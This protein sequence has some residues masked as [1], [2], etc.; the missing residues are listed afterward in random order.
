M[1]PSSIIRRAGIVAGVTILASSSAAFAQTDANARP[2]PAPRAAQAGELAKLIAMIHPVGD[3]KVKGTVMFEKTAEGV[4]IT[5]KVGGLEPDSRH[6]F[7]IHEYGDLGSDDATSAGGH[8]NP[9]SHPHG[10]PDQQPRH[11]GDLGELKADADGNATHVITVKNITLG[12]GSH[13]ILGRAVIVHA[14][15]DDGSQPSGN[16]GDRIGAGVIGISKDAM[17]ADHTGAPSPAPATNGS[18]RSGGAVDT[19]GV[20]APPRNG[21]ITEDDSAP[22]AP[23]TTPPNA[24]E[25][26]K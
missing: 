2:D 9:D 19:S 23:G 26:R 13:G 11:A 22:A 18:A 17:S 3:S 15:P 10:K 7:H 5:A 8:F 14:K 4:K 21:S 16:G 6:G 24:S 25:E 12:H 20:P 1:R